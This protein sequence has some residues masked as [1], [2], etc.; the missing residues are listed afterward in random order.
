[1]AKLRVAVVGAGLGGIGAG[2]Y[3]KRYADA[4]VTIFEAE[5]NVG[6]TWYRNQFPGAEVDTPSHMYSYSFRPWDWSQPYAT[7]SELVEY[8]ETVVREYG[9]ESS[10]RLS[11][12]VHEIRYV[13]N[14]AEWVV[15][16]ESGVETFDAV[17]SAVGMLSDPK[18]PDW[19]G[20]EKF[21]GQAFHTAHWPKNI[22]LKGKRVAVVGTGSTASQVVPSVAPHA[23]KLFLFQRQPAWVVPKADNFY[24]PER[25][26]ELRN[27]KA[28]LKLRYSEFWRREKGS[29]G[30]AMDKPGSKFD[31]AATARA[32]G[33]IDSVFEG[34]DDLKKMVTP[35][36]PYL[37]KRP[38][39]S[40]EFYP[41][42][43]RDNVQLVPHAV[44]EVT[45]D[46]VIDSTGA[47][48]EIDVLIA[49]TGFKA[50]QYL[51]TL[52]VIGLDDKT[53]E[54]YWD[55]EPQAYMGSMVPGFPN[56]FML[57][58]PNTNG[59]A[60]LFALEQQA[61]FA[62]KSLKRMKKKSATS[63]EVKQS[64]FVKYNNWVDKRMRGTSYMMTNNYFKSESGRVV[65]Q[66]PDGVILFWILSRISVWKATKLNKR[67]N[68]Y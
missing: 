51:S 47:K 57:Y 56:F 55:G 1:M 49:A 18:V 45:A 10:L 26:E 13:T 64:S 5:D 65:T 7:Q 67:R 22:D 46:G 21:A 2:V 50:A 58:G 16:S 34:R 8:M 15:T 12:R 38:V 30:G 17:I 9:L 53:L 66:W 44:E 32:L 23:E 42:L 52:P 63:V 54:D 31:R 37:G 33:Y 20:A 6:G 68:N 19:P 25:R 14:Q 43:L 48:H 27:K 35:D 41:A 39:Q 4:D 3:L 28:R 36:Y 61:V 24:T 59:Y 40:S 11:T 60:V 29:I 62:A